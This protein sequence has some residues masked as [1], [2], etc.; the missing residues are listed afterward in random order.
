MAKSKKESTTLV[1]D[2]I[3]TQNL[4]RSKQDIDSWRLALQIAEDRIKPNR[5]QYIKLCNEIVLDAHIAGLITQRR[6]ALL[7][8]KF[9]LL[10][11]GKED[12]AIK[13]IFESKWF[14]HFLSLAWESVLYGHSLIQ[15]FD[16]TEFGYNYIGI[17]PRENVIPE[18]KKVTINQGDTENSFSY[19]EPGLIDWLIEAGEPTDLGLFKA[20]APSFIF[21]KN[22]ILWWAQYTEIFG[23]PIRVGKTN[24]RNNTDMQRM[25]NNLKAMG[26]AAYGVFQEGESIEFIESTKGDAYNVYDKLIERT[27]SELSKLLVGQTMTTDNGSS[28]SQAEVHER[29]AQSIF[30]SDKRMITFLVNGSLLPKMILHGFPLEGYTF[31]WAEQKD[32]GKIF[33]QYIQVLG[34]GKEV[35]DQWA[36]ETFGM[37]ISSK[38]DTGK[39]TPKLH[40]TGDDILEL[41]HNIAN[42]YSHNCKNHE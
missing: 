30:E 4:F 22:A 20:A 36:T 34:A 26:T 18:F 16:V 33:D 2:R 12:D 14:N 35:D 9:R 7:S 10:K 27:N 3:T 29:I 13:P 39:T 21:K 15:L 40:N 11:D 24:S 17:V 5:L 8:C 23:M 38:K 25:A 19:T 28:K 31:E 6:N 42:L 41:H 37:P 32:I 1:I